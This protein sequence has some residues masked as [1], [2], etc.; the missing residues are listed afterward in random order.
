MDNVLNVIC[1]CCYCLILLIV[2]TCFLN[3]DLSHHSNAAFFYSTEL[4]ALEMIFAYTHFLKNTL[5]FSI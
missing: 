1:V 5:G 4:F 3:I 2:L